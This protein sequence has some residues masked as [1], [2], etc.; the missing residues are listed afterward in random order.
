M[1]SSRHMRYRDIPGEIPC[2]YPSDLSIPWPL[3]HLRFPSGMIPMCF[4]SLIPS[5]P[6]LLV[7]GKYGRKWQIYTAARYRQSVFHYFLWLIRNQVIRPG[8]SAFVNRVGIIDR[9]GYDFFAQRRDVAHGL[10]VYEVN[11]QHKIVGTGKCLGLFYGRGGDKSSLQARVQLLY[12]L[13]GRNMLFAK[14]NWR[15]TAGIC[16]KMK[17]AGLP[18]KNI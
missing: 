8:S 16:L 14:K 9:P 3:A 2:P 11:A 18:L 5:P 15:F 7:Y 17:E 4:G 6:F 12:R 10:G 13:K 1:P